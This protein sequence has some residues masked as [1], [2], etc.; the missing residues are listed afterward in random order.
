MFCCCAVEPGPTENFGGIEERLRDAGFVKTSPAMDGGPAPMLA[1]LGEDE[2][3]DGKI[4]EA[5]FTGTPENHGLVM[6]TS[7]PLCIIVKMVQEDK[8]AAEWNKTV[9]PSQRIQDY[10]RVV[11]V[12][13]VNNPTKMVKAVQV[14][15]IRS[16]K[17]ER[18][19]QRT[20]TL[21]RPGEIGV[22]LHYRKVDS[23]AP[24]F[25]KI[26]PGLLQQWNVDHPEETVAV[27]DRIISV[28]GKT[29]TP[30]E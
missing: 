26:S 13:G 1:S 29:G 3:S 10:D 25:Q 19:A 16:I 30:E 14:D 18:P 9:A 28:N 8:G 12:N 22:V 17:F 2:E 7:D 23:S 4:F 20:V 11:E 21:K 5:K 27:H 6:D 24:W 15:E